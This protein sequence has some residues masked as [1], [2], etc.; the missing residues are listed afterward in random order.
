MKKLRLSIMAVPSSGAPWRL[1]DP[2][3][4]LTASRP[5]RGGRRH[6]DRGDIMALR[7]NDTIPNLE[8]ETDQGRIS[9]HD[10][11]GDG[12]AVIFS[13]PKDFTPVCTTEFGAV[14]QLD[15]E[16]QKRG[17]KVLG[18]SVDGVE[19]HVKWKSTSTRGGRRAHLPHRRRQGPPDLQGL[20][21]AAGRGLP[22]RGAHP[23]RHGDRA[24]RSTS[25]GRTEGEAVDDLPDDGGPQLLEIVRAIDAL[26]TS[27]GRGVATPADWQPGDDVI[28]PGR[29]QGRRGARQ[30]RRVHDRPALPA[31]DQ[32]AGLIRQ[33][34]TTAVPTGTRS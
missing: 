14:A 25:S 29:G 6:E 7:I 4:I 15:K 34:A 8:V 24:D 12:W 5:A 10:W 31:Q 33:A 19:D 32:A 9:L 16:W 1:S 20:R 23:Q 30:V 22:A 27:S 13:H 11:V 28:I 26:Q 2:L 18:V 3:S 17:V 21:H